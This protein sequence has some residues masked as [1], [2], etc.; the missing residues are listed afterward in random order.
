MI[1]L[2]CDSVDEKIWVDWT[3]LGDA[4]F[5]TKYYQNDFEALEGFR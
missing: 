3:D 4:V 5:F 1:Y 2:V